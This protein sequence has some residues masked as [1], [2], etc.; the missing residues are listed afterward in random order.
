MTTCLCR[1][2]RISIKLARNVLSI[3]NGRYCRKFSNETVKDTRTNQANIQMLSN[4]LHSQIFKNSLNEKLSEESLNKVKQHL[5]KHGL[6]DKS[7]TKTNPLSFALPELHGENIDEHFE[8]IAREATKNYFSLAESMSSTMSCI[9][10]KPDKWLFTEGWT[11]YT[12]EGLS[13]SVSCPEEDVL[14]FDVEVCLQ[15]GNVPILATA[16]SKKAW[17][18]NFFSIYQ[19]FFSTML[20]ER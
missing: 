1:S 7:S 15:A 6:W 8:H 4:N 2:H 17:Y 10:E 5:I 11:K 19:H 18:F 3:N 14:V 12:N 13:Q 16:V 9:P 20:A